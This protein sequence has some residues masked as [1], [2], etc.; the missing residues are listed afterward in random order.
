M[1]RHLLNLSLCLCM[2][3]TSQQIAAKVYYVKPSG[4][5]NGS[6]WE[7]ASGDIN[8]MLDAATV[9]DELW[10]AAGNYRPTRLIKSSKKNSRAFMLKDGVSL[11][12]GFQ[13]TEATIADRQRITDGKAYDFQ[14]ET[15]LSGDDDVADQWQ[16]ELMHNSSYQLGWKVGDDEL[17]PGTAGN[18]N[19]ILYG[20]TTTFTHRTI[21]NGLTLRG[22]HAAVWNVK[23]AGAALY[24]QGFVKLE[25]CKVIEN[26]AYFTAQSSTDSDTKGGAVYLMANNFGAS[27]TDCYFR[28]NFSH[29][30]YGNG[31]GGA[32]YARHVQI[33]N[34]EFYDCVALDGGGA[35]Y[36]QGGDIKNCL[37]DDCY[38][39]TG[40]AVYN[41]GDIKGCTIYDCRGLKGGAIYNLGNITETLIAN[42]YADVLEYGEQL[43]GWG[44]GIFNY[45]GKIDGCQVFNN[46]AFHGGGI[47][48]REGK[49][50]NSTVIHNALREK[51]KAKANVVLADSLEWTDVLNNTIYMDDTADDNFVQPT[52]FYGISSDDDQW[53]AVRTASWELKPNSPLKGQGHTVLAISATPMGKKQI[54]KTEWFNLSGQLIAQPQHGIYLERQYWNDGKIETKKVLMK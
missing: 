4:T 25:A 1:K 12:G 8:A 14:Y 31:Y 7:Q 37:F 29:S 32:I 28:N 11:Y 24:A 42:C 50:T 51:N 19:H 48:L 40:G 33:S 17:I 6:S 23:A 39:A 22:G 18:S 53:Q 46:E 36:N 52:N 44:G 38:G 27:I 3:M 10:I 21:I 47:F 26:S 15:I 41:T 5:G 13:G 35:I 30:K 2:A 45:S 43:G 9:G 34:C 54:M 20:G 49:I 16:R